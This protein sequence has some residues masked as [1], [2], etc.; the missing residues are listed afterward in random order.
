MVSR[1]A[2]ALGCSRVKAAGLMWGP[3]SAAAIAARIVR[4]LKCA[5]ADETLVR[6]T[7]PFDEAMHEA[8]PPSLTPDLFLVEQEADGDEDTAQVAYLTAPNRDTA[9]SFLRRA[10]KAM[11]MLNRLCGAVAHRWGLA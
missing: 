8:A 7:Q 2:L 3:H 4:A 10:H 6:F 11:A 1:V 5:G 9:E